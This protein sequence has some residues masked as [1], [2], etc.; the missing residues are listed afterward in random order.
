MQ[1]SN[2][3]IAMRDGRPI[4]EGSR[5]GSTYAGTQDGLFPQHAHGQPCRLLHASPAG[6]DLRTKQRSSSSTL[7]KKRSEEH[8]RTSDGGT[9]HTC[10]VTQADATC[11]HRNHPV[12]HLLQSLMQGAA[13]GMVVLLLLLLLAQTKPRL[14][15]QHLVQVN[16]LG[17]LLCSGRSQLGAGMVQLG[18]LQLGMIDF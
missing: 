9:G 5:R 14:P 11:R 10:K 1:R 17:R 4:P 2:P 7:A 8:G 3:G 12:G 15:P 13:R 6:P 18:L 16:V